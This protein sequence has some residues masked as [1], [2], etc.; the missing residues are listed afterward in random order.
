VEDL[1]FD[2]LAFLALEVLLLLL[3][4]KLSLD[5]LQPHFPFYCRPLSPLPLILG[6][7]LVLVLEVIGLVEFSIFFLPEV[8]SVL[9]LR[10]PL[11]ILAAP[12]VL[13]HR[14]LHARQVQ[15]GVLLLQLVLHR[16]YLLSLIGSGVE[17][18]LNELLMRVVFL[19]ELFHLL[20]LFFHHCFELRELSTHLLPL[21]L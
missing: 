17:K 21:D 13:L 15:L 12:V 1:S 11:L 4:P 6:L 16:V 8:G 5:R 14:L 9:K 2:V 20:V 3:Y 10:S 18:L 19:L 7:R